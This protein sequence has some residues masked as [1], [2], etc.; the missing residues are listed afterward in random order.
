MVI[1]ATVL[2]V[3]MESRNGTWEG[4]QMLSGYIRQYIVVAW[5]GVMAVEGKE[6]VGFWGVFEGRA[7][8]IE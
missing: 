5:T 2:T 4:S 3:D 8:I 6:V 7:G 1:L